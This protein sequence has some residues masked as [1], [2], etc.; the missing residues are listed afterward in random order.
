LSFTDQVVKSE[1]IGSDAARQGLEFNLKS[2]RHYFQ[3]LKYFTQDEGAT[4]KKEWPGR[5]GVDLFLPR[6][7]VQLSAFEARIATLERLLKGEATPTP[8][9]PKPTLAPEP[10]PPIEPAPSPPPPPPTPLPA[11]PIPAP[12]QPVEEP[13]ALLISEMLKDGKKINRA[14]MQTATPELESEM[15][16][17]VEQAVIAIN[18]FNAFSRIPA[19]QTAAL[20]RQRPLFSELRQRILSFK[21][22]LKDSSPTLEINNFEVVLF[23]A[24]NPGRRNPRNW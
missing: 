17:W 20:L 23:P 7:K 15:R 13:N 10:R 6:L 1:N 11:Q 18:C 24:P 22:R 9:Q 19:N 8:A 12:S 3:W 5:Q 21:Q 4:L 16:R 2:H 14:L